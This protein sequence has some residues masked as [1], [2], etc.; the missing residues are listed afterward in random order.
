ME[1]KRL[2]RL[3]EEQLKEVWMEMVLVVDALNFA[4]DRTG[5]EVLSEV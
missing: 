2:K 5:T 3:R 1:L 4:R